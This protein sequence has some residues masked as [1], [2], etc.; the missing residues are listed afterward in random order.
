M[1][2]RPKEAVR[3]KPTAPNLNR[4]RKKGQNRDLEY[5]EARVPRV[6]STNEAANA[7]KRV[8]NLLQF[9]EA[10]PNL[11]ESSF[12]SPMAMK[13]SALGEMQALATSA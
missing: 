7:N 8:L 10:P 3:V 1:S 11:Y 5:D 4:R 6:K 13:D 12:M 2:G 9:G